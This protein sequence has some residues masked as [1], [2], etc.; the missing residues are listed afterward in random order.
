[1]KAKPQLEQMAHRA[2]QELARRL[3]A[4]NTSRLFGFELEAAEPGRAVVTMR[5]RE[6]HRQVH[7]VVHGGIVAA[8]ADTAGA[9][10]IYMALPRGTHMA[11]VELKINYLEPVAQGKVSA[12]GR[13]LRLGR[14][15][16]VSECE[17]RDDAGQ[18]TAKALL[19]FAVNRRRARIR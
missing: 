14:N 1:M 5:V 13:M 16:A 18:L 2:V 6:R 17:V 15:F 12:E 7:G 19:T 8:L 10:A 4:S 11:T 9:L 3:R